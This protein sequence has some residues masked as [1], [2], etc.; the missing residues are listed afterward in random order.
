M[1]YNRT[2]DIR[3]T[4]K[5]HPSVVRHRTGVRRDGTIVGAEIDI[6]FDGGAYTTLSPVVLSRGILHA[7]GAYRMPAASIRGRAVATNTPPNGAFRGFGAP[8]TIFAM[9]R[10]IDRIAAVLGLD[11]LEVRRKNLLHRG[12]TLPCGQVLQED[13]GAEATLERLV[14]ISGYESWK[15]AQRIAGRTPGGSKQT[16]GRKT[17]GSTGA[18]RSGEA[19]AAVARDGQGAPTLAESGCRVRRGLGLSLFPHGSGFTGAGEDKIAG[20]VHVRFDPG[21]T[22]D[23]DGGYE[24]LVSITEMGQGAATILGQIAAETLGVPMER[25][26]VPLPDTSVVPDSGPTVASRTTMIVGRILVDACHDLVRKL[27]AARASGDRG[28]VTGKAIYEPTPGLAWDEAAY[29]GDAYKAYAWGA[30]AVEI[31]IDVDTLEIRP[32]RAWAVVEIGRA[33]NPVLAAGQVEGGMS[34]GFGWAC[35]EEIKSSDG[36]F[37]NDRMATYIVPT[38]LDASPVTVEILE[39]PHPRGPLGA[40]GLGE[41]P[42]DGAAPAFA[43]AVTDATGLFPCELPITPE[44]LLALQSRPPNDFASAAGLP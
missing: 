17:G 6:V 34:Q 15:R 31:E 19:G 23:A 35:L 16:A 30:E 42:I 20:R 18:N 11:P 7:S 40:K 1:I 22:G 24:V 44:R 36:H 29:R 27:I 4:T 25:V 37:L 33:V 38:A 5:R 2:E 28:P 3:A 26:R 43:A 21:T 39:L 32:V 14:E 13:V 10:Q 8:Q 41:L 12:D 9:E